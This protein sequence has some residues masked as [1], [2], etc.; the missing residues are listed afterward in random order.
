MNHND[1]MCLVNKKIC[2][3]YEQFIKG[4]F[5][6]PNNDCD[7]CSASAIIVDTSVE[8]IS[9]RIR[10]VHISVMHLQPDSYLS[11]FVG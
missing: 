5:G 9:R 4:S 2:M 3:K 6:I 11:A 8:G 10:N 1:M 7:L